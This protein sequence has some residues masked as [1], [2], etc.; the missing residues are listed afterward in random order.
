MPVPTLGF[1]SRAVKPRWTLVLAVSAA[2]AA[3]AGCGH[4]S[5]SPTAAPL[6]STM[7]MPMPMPMLSG[8]QAAAPVAAPVATSAVT[9]DNFAF[10]PKAVTVKVGTTVSWTNRDE[11]PHTV[12]AEDGSFKSATL[13]G[14]TNTFSHT[15]TAPGTFTYH[16]TIHPYM[17]GTVEV[18]R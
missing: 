6:T 10:S 12:A 2:G 5:A 18:T 8:E 7:P 3:L 9:I 11:E 14:N 17:S 4:S 13:A 16:C 1:P 15:F